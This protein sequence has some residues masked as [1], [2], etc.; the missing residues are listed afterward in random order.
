[1]KALLFII[2]QIIPYCTIANN[3]VI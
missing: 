1:M 3:E 2:I